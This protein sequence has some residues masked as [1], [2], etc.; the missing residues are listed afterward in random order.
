MDL[1]VG[2]S[3]FAPLGCKITWDWDITPTGTIFRDD[4]GDDERKQS[5]LLDDH[6]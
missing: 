2:H 1:G 3:R 5:L 6:H 4:R